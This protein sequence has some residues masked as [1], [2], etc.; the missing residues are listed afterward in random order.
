MPNMYIKNTSQNECKQD[1]YK[2]QLHFL[3]PAA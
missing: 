3:N 1:E 2:R